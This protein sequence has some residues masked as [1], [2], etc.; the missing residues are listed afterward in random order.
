MVMV[1]ATNITLDNFYSITVVCELLKLKNRTLKDWND[2]FFVVR[3]PIADFRF[4]FKPYKFH[5]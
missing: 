5:F 2:S 4:P 3:I 1:T